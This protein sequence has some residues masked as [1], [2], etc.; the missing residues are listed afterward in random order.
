[1]PVRRLVFHN[2]FTFGI[3]DEAASG[4][5]DQTFEALPPTQKL[6]C[7]LTVGERRFPSTEDLQGAGLV[8]RK[9]VQG[10]GNMAPAISRE[11]FHTKSFMATFDLEAAPAVQHSGVST[12]NSPLNIFIEGLYSPVEVAANKC[13]SLYLTTRNDALMEITR[14]GVIISVRALFSDDFCSI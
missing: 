6:K 3:P 2:A 1:M 9:L 12:N 4:K 8:Y 7:R 11:H 13:N 5:E 14:R 10:L